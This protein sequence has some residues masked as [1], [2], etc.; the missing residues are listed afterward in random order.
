LDRASNQALP[1]ADLISLAQ[2][3]CDSSYT[4]PSDTT[5]YFTAWNSIHT[6]ESKELV[7]TK[8]HPT[9]KYYLS[10]E[11]WEVADGTKA[12]EEGRPVGKLIQKKSIPARKETISR[13]ATPDPF[14]KRKPA[15]ARPVNVSRPITLEPSSS[16]SAP[17]LQPQQSS[18]KVPGAQETSDILDLVSSSENEWP[19]SEPEMSLIN[20]RE[21]RTV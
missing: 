21:G 10:D 14:L 7:C 20:V 5:K 11:G 9:K 19:D 12:N 1:K 3:Y 15:A 16:R 18:P 6:L 13:S 4:V 2:E 8:G 17:A